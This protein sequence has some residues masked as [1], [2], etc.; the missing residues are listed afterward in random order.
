MV[1]AE[2]IKLLFMAIILCYMVT[3]TRNAEG[4]LSYF[5]KMDAMARS[6][7]KL[8]DSNYLNWSWRIKNYLVAQK[9]SVCLSTDVTGEGEAKEKDEQAL[10]IISLLV[11]DSQVATIRSCKSARQAWEALAARHQSVS[12]SSACYLYRKFF[13]IKKE[14]SSMESFLMEV[15]D[16]A[17]S[18]TAIG[19]PI[20]DMMIIAVL[21]NG[22]SPLY[23][24]VVESLAGQAEEKLK[25]PAVAG[26]LRGAE[27]DLEEEETALFAGRKGRKG[28]PGAGGPSAK[29]DKSQVKC[30]T[31]SKMGHYQNECDQ[32]SKEEKKKEDKQREEANLAFK[33]SAGNDDSSSD[34]EAIIQL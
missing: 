4:L 7:T 9:L 20:S 16:T 19:H 34:D 8:N 28:K 24:P 31:C 18:L 27:R 33:M 1:A 6:I 10:S 11:D 22:L 21:L 12:T 14:D 30:F 5:S 25:F 29:K 13:N 3:N 26:R 23:R 2:E 15:K 17:D 32:V